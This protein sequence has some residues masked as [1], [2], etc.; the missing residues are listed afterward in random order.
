MRQRMENM[1]MEPEVTKYACILLAGIFISSLSQVILKKAAMK[2]YHSPVREYFN[3]KVILAYMM[4]AV[5]V[6]CTVIAY[7]G[8]PLSMGAALESTGYLYI[9]FFGVKIFNEKMNIRKWTALAFIV[10]GII[11]YAS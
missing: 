10:T 2:Q 11:V 5:S 4:F 6:F 7:R 1:K 9:T 3:L 8:I